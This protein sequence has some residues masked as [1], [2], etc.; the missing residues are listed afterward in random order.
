MN[1]HTRPPLRTLCALA[2]LWAACND[3]PG[4]GAADMASAADL[5]PPPPGDLTVPPPADLAN[6]SPVL[7]GSVIP[8]LGRTSGG[9]ALT[10][11]GSGFKDGAALALRFA[12]VAA[13]QVKWVSPNQLTAL[14]PA[15]P[16]ALG[17]VDVGLTNGDGTQVT[18][19]GLFRYALSQVAFR[20]AV[21]TAVGA[22]G[23]RG[24]VVYD[25]DGDKLLDLAT[26]NGDAGNVTVQKG[27]PDGT[28]QA[29]VPYP[30]GGVA[31]SY[32]FMLTMADVDGD[33]RQ[34]LLTANQKSTNN[35]TA[36]SI[37]FGNVDGTFATANL[38]LTCSTAQ[39]VATGDFNNDGKLDLVVSC[40][41]DSTV[42]VLLNKGARSFD[43]V[44][45]PVMGKPYAVTVADAD[46]DNAPDI[47]TANSDNGT[48]S[49][50]LNDT[51]GVFMAPKNFPAGASP[52]VVRMIDLDR[53]GYPELVVANATADT[54]SV[55]PG[56]TSRSFGPPAPFTVAGRPEFFL[57]SDLDGD[58]FPDLV[59]ASLTSG[60]LTVLTGK[61]D[62]TFNAPIPLTAGKSPNGLASADLDGDGLPELV[63][64]NYG[65]STVG[66]FKNTSQ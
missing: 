37:L 31:T 24:V 6:A 11:G 7:L 44:S 32:P 25:F 13:T 26:V 18:G 16:G 38:A 5:T 47:L 3:K 45:Y 60:A 58:G 52:F 36:A 65:D 48:I 51:T 53:D 2:L 50:L 34:D 23:P 54:I 9:L 14:L 42:K 22:A 10:I 17:E 59:V 12:G 56:T 27:K 19:P 35:A 57:S 28:F 61:G 20:A 64:T 55:L 15:K 41:G 66:V 30:V 33:G 63:V 21:N 46:G 29:A 1:R 39:G 49:L 4:T 8:G 43:V 40:Q 62:R